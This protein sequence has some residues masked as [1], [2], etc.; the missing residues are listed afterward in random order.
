[1][2]V[3]KAINL[4]VNILLKIYKELFQMTSMIIVVAMCIKAHY[5]FLQLWQITYSY[6]MLLSNI[7][8][9]NPP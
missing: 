4:M 2:C 6:F 9:L 8:K 3:E 7:L 1:M 5:N